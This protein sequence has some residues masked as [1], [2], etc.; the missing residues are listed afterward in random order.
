MRAHSTGFHG[1]GLAEPECF[2]TPFDA[3]SIASLAVTTEGRLAHLRAT[4]EFA[5]RR[6]VNAEWV[7]MLDEHVAKLSDEL[8]AERLLA[9]ERGAAIA[10]RD[11]AYAERDAAIAE[12]D[13]A[14][15]ARDEA[16][17]SLDSVLSS[18]ILALGQSVPQAR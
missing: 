11:T 14:E 4:L 17:S 12:R 18:R 2:D 13:A 15:M 7:R 10:E 8:R 3:S 9:K 5:T 6:G 16:V 1:R